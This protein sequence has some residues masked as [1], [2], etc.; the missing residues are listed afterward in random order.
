MCQKSRWFVMLSA[1][2]VLTLGSIA[3]AADGPF[4]I[5]L[6][7]SKK[8][9]AKQFAALPAFL[10]DKGTPVELVGTQ[11]FADAIGKFTKGD[12]DAMFCASGP[13]GVLLIMDVATPTVR[14]VAEDGSSGGHVV[15]LAKKGAAPFTGKPEYFT[16]KKVIYPSLATSG[17]FWFKALM[18]GSKIEVT[19]VQASSHSAAI[20]ALAKDAADFAVAKNWVWESEKSKYADLVQVGEDKG[21]NPENALLVS[22]KANPAVADKV[23]QA[24]LALETDSSANAAAVK[25]GMKITK[26]IKTTTADFAYTV[27]VLK[28][29]GITKDFDPANLDKK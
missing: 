24:L 13:A 1:L 7:Q 29:A 8:D 5:A 15:I 10:A 4:R 25:S 22:K 3:S 27:D 2:T 20:D 17:E 21:E 11:N 28:K 19:A 14:P 12:V 6:V 23:A 16:G 9:Q 18:A 26:F